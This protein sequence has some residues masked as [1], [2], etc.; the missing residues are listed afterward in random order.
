MCKAHTSIHHS[1]HH[2]FQSHSQSGALTLKPSCSDFS[3][4]D[5]KFVFLILHDICTPAFYASKHHIHSLHCLASWHLYFF[6]WLVDLQ[7]HQGSKVTLFIIRADLNPISPCFQSVDEFAHQ[8]GSVQH[9]V[10]QN[11]IYHIF[12][13]FEYA[14]SAIPIYLITFFLPIVAKRWAIIVDTEVLKSVL[15]VPHIPKIQTQLFALFTSCVFHSC[16]WLWQ[17]GH[18]RAIFLMLVSLLRFPV[19]CKVPWFTSWITYAINFFILTLDT[20]F[21]SAATLEVLFQSL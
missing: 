10:Q 16:P 11:A 21:L 3:A 6:R 8:F 9:K 19:S 14:T 2:C 4:F 5:S 12:H 17:G 15:H 20:A 1:Q 7:D 13:P 18:L